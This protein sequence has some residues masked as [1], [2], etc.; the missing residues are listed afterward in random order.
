MLAET[1]CLTEL[2]V[3]SQRDA[4]NTWRSFTVSNDVTHPLII[5]VTKTFVQHVDRLR[6][7]LDNIRS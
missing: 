4:L 1:T 6:L 7:T 3:L 2:I 5:D